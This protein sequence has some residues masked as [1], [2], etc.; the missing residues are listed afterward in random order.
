M[1][2]IS[3]LAPRLVRLVSAVH[4]RAPTADDWLAVQEAI[5][6]HLDPEAGPS[7]MLELLDRLLEG[8]PTPEAVAYPIGYPEGANGFVNVVADVE[9][10]LGSLGVD[11]QGEQLS[12]PL[13]ALGVRLVLFREGGEIYVVRPW[14]G[15]FA[16][17]RGGRVEEGLLVE[18]RFKAP[19]TVRALDGRLLWTIEVN[20]G[21]F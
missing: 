13:P 18:G 15:R 14:S 5:E 3:P 7:W 20:E 8:R 10:A 17:S 11:D 12:W 21:T 2:P 19:R 9:R 1:G 4:G 6:G 16:E